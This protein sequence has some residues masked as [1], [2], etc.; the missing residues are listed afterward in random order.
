MNTVPQFHESKIYKVPLYDFMRFR[1]IITDDHEK[2]NKRY[3]LKCQSLYGHCFFG[4]IMIKGVN[5]IMI[6]IVIN[7]YGIE[8][9]DP[10]LI[11]HE[12]VHAKNMI[13]ERAGIKNSLINDEPEAYLM[14]WLVN[15]VTDFYNKVTRPSGTATS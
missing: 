12:C 8:T 6:K 10:G 5:R 4:P 2:I 7:P 15:T 1:V 11:A 13:F 9:I 3:G 14:R